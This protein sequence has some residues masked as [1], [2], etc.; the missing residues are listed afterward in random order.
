MQI[1]PRN[2]SK[3]E[4][5]IPPQHS[6]DF[7]FRVHRWRIHWYADCVDTWTVYYSGWASD[8]KISAD[9]FFIRAKSHF[10]FFSKEN[11]QRTWPTIT[12]QISINDKRLA[13]FRV[14]YN[15]ISNLNTGRFIVKYASFRLCKLIT[16]RIYFL[17]IEQLK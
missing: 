10:R 3:A 11:I 16:V 9:F 2:P 4:F 7:F 6:S 12:K 14:W 13:F 8:E 15:L 1:R 5:S 17:S